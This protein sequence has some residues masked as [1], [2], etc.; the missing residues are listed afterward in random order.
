[1]VLGVALRQ[2][3]L[4]RLPEY[5]IPTALEV[6][7]ALPLTPSG[8][9]DRLGLPTPDWSRRPLDQTYVAPRTPTEETLA[10]LAAAVLGRE[11]VGVQDNFFALGGHSLLATQ[12]VARLR[13]TFAIDLPLRSLFEAPTI[14]HLAEHVEALQWVM[15][16]EQVPAGAADADYEEGQL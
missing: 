9:V 3:A 16:A 13:E 2:W 1:V 12:L 4:E 5:M 8:K 10:E 11:R 14:A 15:Q 7:D 6:L